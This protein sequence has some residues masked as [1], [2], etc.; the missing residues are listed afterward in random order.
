MEKHTKGCVIIALN[1]RFMRLRILCTVH[2]S[3]CM[4]TVGLIC[5]WLC[6]EVIVGPSW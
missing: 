3:M 5:Q 4:V 1:S 2:A 6:L